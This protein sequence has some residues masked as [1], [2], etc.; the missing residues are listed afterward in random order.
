MKKRVIIIIFRNVV[1]AV[2]PCDFKQLTVIM[3]HLCFTETSVIGHAF[4]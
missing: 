2:V 3:S 4:M 1:G